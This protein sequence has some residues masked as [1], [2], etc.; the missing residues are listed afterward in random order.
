MSVDRRREKSTMQSPA[1]KRH[2]YKDMVWS[3]FIGVTSCFFFPGRSDLQ[4]A[5]VIRGKQ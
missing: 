4:Q 2:L 5:D 1:Q 3:I